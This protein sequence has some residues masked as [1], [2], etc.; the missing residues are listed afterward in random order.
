MR[1]LA[2]ELANLTC[3]LQGGCD[4][5]GVVL[6]VVSVLYP[7]SSARSCSSD[8]DMVDMIADRSSLSEYSESSLG[9]TL[10]SEYEE[11]T[12]VMETS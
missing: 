6:S 3:L 7:V 2:A 1:V 12:L 11:S 5:L 8:S 9:S 10:E 4:L